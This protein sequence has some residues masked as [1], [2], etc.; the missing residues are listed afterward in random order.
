MDTDPKDA[1]NALMTESRNTV[2]FTGAGISTESGIPDFRSP[3]GVWTQ[4]KPIPFQDFI[5][6]KEARLETWRRKFNVEK[7]MKDAKPNVGHLAISQ[8]VACGQV[9]KIITQNRHITSAI[10]STTSPSSRS[11]TN[12]SIKGSIGDFNNCQSYLLW[13][14]K[15]PDS[16]VF[17]SDLRVG[18]GLIIWQEHRDK[19]CI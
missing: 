7:T 18:Y 13:D 5:A 17:F 1:F 11:N 12:I 4:N 8:M 6:S 14:W 16:L 15:L 3:G 2:I 19:T 9:G 10:S